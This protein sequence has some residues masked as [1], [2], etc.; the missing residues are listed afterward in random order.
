MQKKRFLDWVST[1]PIAAYLGGILGGFNI[2]M[3][4]V[5]IAMLGPDGHLPPRL[6]VLGGFCMLLS[7]W[8][9][10]LQGSG[11][12]ESQAKPKA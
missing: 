3:A 1:S 4:A 11:K 12:R 6:A 2:G 9:M 8:T 5:R 7:I 10:L